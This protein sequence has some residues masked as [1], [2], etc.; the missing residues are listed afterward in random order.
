M[1]NN[2][3][4]FCGVKNYS[5]YLI[6]NDKQIFLQPYES[7]NFFICPDGFKRTIG[8]TGAFILKKVVLTIAHLDHDITNNCPTN[9]KALCQKCHLSYDKDH[10][11][12]NAR[13]TLKT[14]KGLLELAF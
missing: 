4:Q 5:V 7:T 6:E 12:K 14:K 3:C 2:C 9:L 1:A 13:Q 10:H 8:R 11:R